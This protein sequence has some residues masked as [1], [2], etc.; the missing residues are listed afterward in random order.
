MLFGCIPRSRR[1]ARGIDGK[2]ISTMQLI[3]ISL[4]ELLTTIS[5]IYKTKLEAKSKKS[6]VAAAAAAAAAFFAFE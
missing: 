3:L 1:S 2:V 6:R 4:S 5:W